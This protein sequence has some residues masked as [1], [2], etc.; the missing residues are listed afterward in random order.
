MLKKKQKNNKKSITSSTGSTVKNK[1]KPI[2]YTVMDSK[3]G[4]TFS[5]LSEAIAYESSCRAKNGEF[6]AIVETTKK[7][8]HKIV[9]SLKNY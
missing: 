6:L 3:K 4:K 8:T 7:P 9:S 5:T 1:K 2:T